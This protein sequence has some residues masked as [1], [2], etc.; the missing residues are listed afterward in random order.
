[1]KARVTKHPDYY[2]AVVTRVFTGPTRYVSRYGYEWFNAETRKIADPFLA[3]KLSEI[4]I[5]AG[6]Y[7]PDHA[8]GPSK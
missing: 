7:I 1:M 2:E 4:A 3:V 8:W 6:Q 5:P